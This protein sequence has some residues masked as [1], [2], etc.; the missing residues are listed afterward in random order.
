MSQMYFKPQWVIRLF[1]GFIF[2]LSNAYNNAYSSLSFRLLSWL[3]PA[4]ALVSLGY[5]KKYHWLRYILLMWFF[6]FFFSIGVNFPTGS[7]F[8]W[9]FK[10]FSFLQ[11]FRNPY[12]KAG[13]ILMLPYSL[14]FAVGWSWFFKKSKIIAFTIIIGVCGV[15][16]WPMWSGGVTNAWVK[17]PEYYREA[18]SWISSQNGD[19]KIIQMPL[20]AG[21]GVKYDWDNTYQGIEPSE[22]LF[23]TSSI[24]R[25]V[26]FNKPYYNIL[27]QKFGI[28]SSGSFG[29]DPDISKSE[30]I[31]PYL[32]EELNKLAVR[33]I[34]FHRDYD[35]NTLNSNSTN[36]RSNLEKEQNI[37]YIKSF[38]KLDIYEVAN[39]DSISRLYSPNTNIK[40]L[41][42]S[43]DFY[44]FMVSADNAVT[45]S[46][47]DL[48][49]PG[50]ELFVDNR[51]IDTHKK[52]FG[53]ANSWEINKRGNYEAIVKYTPQD[54][55]KLGWNIS[56]MSI[57]LVIVVML[58]FKYYEYKKQ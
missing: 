22:F 32:W 45:V 11:A 9:F 19:F 53:Y 51:K 15:L 38:G 8:T 40:I 6:G 10:N 14:L 39:P 13:L 47:L 18:D 2:F 33:Y 30:F 20:I 35:K 4:V 27:L 21:D 55:V 16:V 31:S 5:V 41:S 29:P 28:F 24:G 50:W 58:A 17:I 56:F 7:I 54:N 57:V 43:T 3:V 34:V 42:K 12:E 37:K 25:N 52:M 44:K 23:K 46:L 1:Q 36:T 48:Y 49:D 26:A